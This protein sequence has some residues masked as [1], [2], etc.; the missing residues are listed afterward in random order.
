MPPGTLERMNL[1][2]TRS[3]DEHLKKLGRLYFCKKCIRSFHSNEN[4]DFC[5]F[6]G[7][8]IRE[9]NGH[10]EQLFRY[11]CPVCYKTTTTKDSLKLCPKCNNKFLHVHPTDNMG[12][13]E[14]MTMRKREIFSNI[15]RAL[16]NLG[17][18]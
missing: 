12:K 15:S 6:C 13:R 17:R 1:F 2:G 5:K 4:I 9:L 8:E 10:K 11:Y 3:Y 7:D 16:K 18:K 14:F